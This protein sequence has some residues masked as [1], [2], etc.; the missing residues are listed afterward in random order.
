MATAAGSR[1]ARGHEKERHAERQAGCWIVISG[2]LVGGIILSWYFLRQTEE[3]IM[4]PTRKP[5]ITIAA[6]CLALVV[7]FFLVTA[8]AQQ[9]AGSPSTTTTSAAS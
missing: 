5:E 6:A 2:F 8:R 4:P 7:S 3:R 1:R 9:P